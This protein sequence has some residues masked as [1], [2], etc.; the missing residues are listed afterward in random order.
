[1]TKYKS[2]TVYDQV[3][4]EEE[5]NYDKG[6]SWSLLKGKESKQGKCP[7]PQRDPM[8]RCYDLVQDI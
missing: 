1:M 4:I 6:A 8:E 5:R 7:K 3:W 2:P